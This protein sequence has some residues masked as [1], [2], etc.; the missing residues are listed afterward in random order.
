MYLKTSIDF[1]YILIFLRNWKEMT[2]Q[3]GVDRQS[4]SENSLLISLK[5]RSKVN[6]SQ[7]QTQTRAMDSCKCPLSDQI[8]PVCKVTST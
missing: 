7:L 2:Q 8:A 3:G 1:K 4:A 6:T 5:G